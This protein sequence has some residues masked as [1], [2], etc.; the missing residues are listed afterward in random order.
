MA[1]IHWFAAKTYEAYT[2][3]R[4]ASDLF[5]RK[6]ASGKSARTQIKKDATPRLVV[7]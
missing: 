1:N 5:E 4:P 3:Q 2:R 7:T 6:Q